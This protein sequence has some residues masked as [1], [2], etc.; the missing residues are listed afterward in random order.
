MAEA[1]AVVSI[2][3]ACNKK[4]LN[5]LAYDGKALYGNE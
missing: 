4:Y 1:A 2:V 5:I 3:Y